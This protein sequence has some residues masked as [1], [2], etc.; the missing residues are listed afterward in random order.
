M[1]QGVSH[2]RGAVASQSENRALSNEVHSGGVLIQVRENRSKR[3]AGTQFRRGRRIF[4]IHIHHKVGVHS[5]ERHLPARIA[6][7]RAV[8]VGLH[9]FADCKPIR[10]F[11]G[12]DSDVFAHERISLGLNDGAGFEKRLDPESAILTADAGVLSLSLIFTSSASE[13]ASIFFITRPR[14][15]LTVTSLM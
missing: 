2:S 8:C 11:F 7:I 13:S 1:R 12:R 3:L 14:C 4:G 15:A 10:S 6:T 9:K 5:K